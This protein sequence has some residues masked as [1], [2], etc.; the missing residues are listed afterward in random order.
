[1]SPDKPFVDLPK[2]TEQSII[3]TAAKLSIAPKRRLHTYWM[4]FCCLA[5]VNI[6]SCSIDAV[7][8]GENVFIVTNH[9]LEDGT[10]PDLFVS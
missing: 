9:T 10:E 3:P 2:L 4:K 6:W 8:A 5:F 7:Q 1:M